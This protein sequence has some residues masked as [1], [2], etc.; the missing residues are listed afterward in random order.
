MSTATQTK[1]AAKK[2][3]PQPTAVNPFPMSRKKRVLLTITALL[4]V[5]VLVATLVVNAILNRGL[6]QLT[7]SLEL[8]GLQATVTVV[9]DANGTPHITAQNEHDLYMAQG[10][11]QAQDRLFQMDLSRRQASGRLAEVVGE[12]V[13]DQ[14]KYFR[15][16]G[17]RRAAQKSLGE[18]EPATLEVMQSFADGVNAYIEQGNLALEFT[19][20]GYDPEPW[21]PLDTLT[22]AK[23]MAY[24]LGGH[25]NSQAFHAYLLQNFDEALARELFPQDPGPDVYIINKDELNLSGVL[26]KVPTH[27]PE[28]GSNNWVVGADK[29]ATGKPLLANDPHLSIASPSVWYPMHLT[30]GDLNVGGVIFGGCPGIIVGSNDYVSW[31]VTNTGPDVQQLYIEK[32]NP[33][34]DKQFEYMGQYEDALVHDETVTVKGGKTIPF[35]VLETRHG[36]IITDWCS[37][38]ED[39]GDGS[40][41]LALR[42]TMQDATHEMTAVLDMNRAK[43]WD[44]FSKALEHFQVPTQNF[45]FASVDGTIAYRANGLIPISDNDGLLPVPGYDGQHEWQG[46]IPYDQLPAV[47]NPEKGYIATAN[48]KVLDQDGDYPYHITDQWAQPFRM[49][50]IDEVLASKDKITVDDMKALQYDTLDKAAQ[51]YVPKLCAALESAGNLTERQQQ[52]IALLKSWDYTDAVDKPQPMIYQFWKVGILELLYYDKMDEDMLDLFEC[53]ES[54][55]YAL[56]DRAMAG[57]K[58]G[59]IEQCG[60]LSKLLS[61]ALDKALDRAESL[62]G[63]DMSAWQWGDFHVSVFPHPLGNAMEILKALYNPMDPVP[64]PGSN[65]TVFAAGYKNDSGIHRHGASWRYVI[66]MADTSQASHIVGPGVAEHF[67]SRFYQNNL[68]LWTQ[69]GYRTLQMKG[70]VEGQTLTLQP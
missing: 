65:T 45:V 36:P 4:M 5:F 2:A 9:R 56:L 31:G 22:I 28:N 19:L 38:D 27:D 69:G 20:L 33:N 23:Y 55:T 6:P 40:T 49:Q 61:D 52:A 53:M 46:Y 15:A 14:D 26:D 16:L 50:R 7:G 68:L 59:W 8:S 44:E 13:V 47:V 17:L 34:N 42:W 18:Y 63:K 48:Y 25:Y 60:G 41:E 3:K 70:N 1:P 58:I 30:C 29:S 12:D 64:L 66:D 62:Q 39:K 43:N 51:Q 67:R 24:D 57:E 10:F 35:E 21:T 54:V 11:V 37:T 32:R